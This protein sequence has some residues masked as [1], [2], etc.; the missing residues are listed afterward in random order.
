M[1]KIELFIFDYG[2]QGASLYFKYILN[3]YNVEQADYKTGADILNKLESAL[4]EYT[5]KKQLSKNKS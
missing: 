4:A 2:W 3:K 1:N 5:D